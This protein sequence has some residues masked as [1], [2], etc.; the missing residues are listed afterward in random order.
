MANAAD[1]WE[2]NS[3]G[4]WYVDKQCILCSVCA[5]VAP[6]NFRESAAGDHDIVYKQP[7]SDAEIAQ[8]EDA[9]TQCPVEAIG[10]DAA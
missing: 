5:T 7:S 10:S 1:K 6:D 9:K 4:K 3:A 2:D 8:C